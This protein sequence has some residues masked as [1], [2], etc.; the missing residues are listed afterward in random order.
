MRVYP[1]AK[2][3]AFRDFVC[4]HVR[5][6]QSMKRFRRSV[7]DTK[8]L[9]LRSLHHLLKIFGKFALRLEKRRLFGLLLVGSFRLRGVVETLDVSPILHLRRAVAF[10]SREALLQF[11]VLRRELVYAPV[12]ATTMLAIHRFGIFNL[13][14]L[15]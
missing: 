2:L 15:C 5:V 3:I 14:C 11:L 8:S 7:G 6:W 1:R 4:N 13:L 10:I 12:A 9:A